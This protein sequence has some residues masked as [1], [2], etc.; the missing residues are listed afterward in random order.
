MRSSAAERASSSGAVSLIDA[1]SAEAP[2]SSTAN[3]RPKAA[4]SAAPAS[5]GVRVSRSTKSSFYSWTIRR[6]ASIPSAASTAALW[7]G[8]PR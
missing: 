6:T 1:A 7:N 4:G 5:A 2:S 8:H 3:C